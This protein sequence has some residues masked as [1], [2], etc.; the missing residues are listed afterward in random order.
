MEAGACELLT[1]NVRLVL[2]MSVRLPLSMPFMQI[3]LK[4]TEKIL[5]LFYLWKIKL[6]VRYIARVSFNLF[7]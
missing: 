3:V 5:N 7:V 2:A 1:F 4:P 6:Y